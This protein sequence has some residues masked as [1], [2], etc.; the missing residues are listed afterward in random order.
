MTLENAHAFWVPKVAPMNRD[1]LAQAVEDEIE[2][3]RELRPQLSSRL[4]RATGILTI[5]LSVRPRLRPIR[6]RV[7]SAGDRV[8][9]LVNSLNHNGAVYSVDA[10][11]FSCSCPD[12]HSHGRGCK[13]SISCYI[14][15]RVA[16]RPRRGC[17][18]CDSGWVYLAEEILDPATGEISETVNPVRCARCG[19]GLT[20][21]FV[22]EWLSSQRWIYA[23][24]RADN[25]HEYC[26]RREAGDE[27][28][29]EQVV[30]HIREW[31][32]WYPWWGRWY[33]QYVAGDHVYWTMGS[34]I[35]ET[36]LIN[37]K[38]LE[39]VRLDQL[40]NKGGGGIV[41]PWLHGD[42]EAERAELRRQESAQDEL[43]EGA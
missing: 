7:S 35:P 25:P 41:W 24:S 13:H 40:T 26:L 37:R 18:S 23:R 15:K 31:G 6:V 20:H 38:T 9:F 5:Q 17:A 22:Q 14:L 39:Q 1:Q 28:T 16:S 11:S 3:L 2:R 42:V 27:A 12:A 19:D 29:F 4:D 8:R 32:S 21:E 43:R 30:E 33:L 10:A 34:P 36:V